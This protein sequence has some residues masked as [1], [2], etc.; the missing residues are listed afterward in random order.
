MDRV[1]FFRR[2]DNYLKFSN[3]KVLFLASSALGCLIFFIIAIVGTIAAFSPQTISE[4][5]KELPFISTAS[6]VNDVLAA[7]TKAKNKKPKGE[8]SFNLPSIFNDDVLINANAS[9]SGTLTAP[10][11]L[12]GLVAGQ[13]I[14]ITGDLQNPTISAS[15]GGVLSVN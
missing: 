4:R 8:I 15:T 9:V 14:S 5:I 2:K 7:A 3:K 6:N 1:S 13:N 11:I 12:Y 10:N